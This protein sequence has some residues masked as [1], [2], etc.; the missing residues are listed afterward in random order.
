[1]VFQMQLIFHKNMSIFLRLRLLQGLCELLQN[2]F[3][4]CFVQWRYADNAHC[5]DRD[6]TCSR[7]RGRTHGLCEGLLQFFCQKVGPHTADAW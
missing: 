3:A 1:M 6:T 5:T 4:T 7:V 2:L